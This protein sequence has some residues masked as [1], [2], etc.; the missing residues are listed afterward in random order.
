MTTTSTP[1]LTREQLG[2]LLKQHDIQPTSQRLHIAE[3][4]F[5]AKQHLSAD[6]VLVNLRKKTSLRP[7]RQFIIH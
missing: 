5:S 1:P 2:S 3:I 6:Q 4:L 7:R